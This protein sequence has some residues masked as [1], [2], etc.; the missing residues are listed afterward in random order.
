[1]SELK[2]ISP[3]LD[4]FAMG[5]PISDHNGVRCCPAM[6]N[7]ADNRYIVKI[8]S[9]PASQVQ[10]DALLL[11]GA[12]SDKQDALSYFKS[13]AS[14]ITEEAEILQKL[15]QLEGFIPFIKWQTVPMEEDNGYD[16]YLLSAYQLTLQ[17][18]LRNHP[19]THLEALN[20]GL[21]LCA[22]LTVCRRSGYIY[23][24]LKPNNI[25]I[26]PERGYRIGDLGFLKLSTLKYASLPERYRSQYTAPEI[27]DAYAAPNT[28][29]DIYAAGLIL[30]QVFNNGTLP[31]TG[32]AA[33]QES[34]APPAFADYEMAEIILKACAPDPADRW[35]DPVDMGQALVSYMQRNG[36]H[37]TPITPVAEEEVPVSEDEQVGTFEST[38]S[39]PADTEESAADQDEAE[40]PVDTSSEEAAEPVAE[41]A[42]YSEDEEGNLTFITDEEDETLPGDDAEEEITYTEV[43][44]EVSDMLAQADEIIAHPAPDPVVQPEAIDVPIPPL[45]EPESEPESENPEETQKETETECDAEAATEST[46]TDSEEAT[47]TVTDVSD[48]EEEEEAMPVKRK[49]H[50]LRNSLLILSALALLALGFL[51][52]KHYYLQPIEAI[53]LEESSSGA[54]TVLVTS[55]INEE[56][57]YVVCSD[58]YGNKHT[59]PVENGKAVFADLAPNSAYTI[60]VAVSGFHKL[61][62]DTTAGYTTPVQTN[63]VQFTAVTGTEDGSIILSFAIDGPDA[64]QWYI[65]YTSDSN[66]FKESIF[67]GHTLTLNG[68]TIGKEYTFSLR[69]DG[70]QRIG[71]TTEVTYTASKIIKATNLSITGFSENTLTASWSAPENTEVDRW[72]VRCYNDNGFDNTIVTTESTASFEITDT[73]ASYTVE[74]TAAGM[75][76]NERIFAAANSLLVNSFKVDK[77]DTNA[78]TLS[79]K[80][81]EN[82][83][84]DGWT[85]SYTVDG[86]AAKE[87]FFSGS[88]ATL[89]PVVPG[90]N[91]IFT[92]KPSDGGAVLGGELTY[93]AAAAPAFSAYGVNSETLEFRMCRRPSFTGWD[94]WDVSSSDYRTEFD[95]GEEAAFVIKRTVDY[96]HTEDQV[97][98][99]FVI[100]DEAG[101][102]IDADATESE[103]W[104]DMWVKGYC[105]LDVPSIPQT[106]GKYTVEIYFNGALAADVPF[107][108]N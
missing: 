14:G 3:M 84:Q 38:D 32:D 108:V 13:L 65:S 55:P 100:R 53:V 57:L 12:Y 75:S 69:P 79:W 83:P 60:K 67:S 62:G 37:D 5:D 103:Y 58:T 26:T 59:A 88:T 50:W 29:M 94:R 51:F 105:E 76:V 31:F 99:L 49:S 34:F 7:D 80:L 72:T 68:F 102:V 96:V 54:L 45:S 82:V 107:T 48:D 61:T 43:S 1:M 74:V 24:D 39:Q 63:I 47:D 87:L 4:N 16:V 71:G 73:T 27:S 78:L 95:A 81:P 9:N 85:L 86:S 42:I 97:V 106:P 20:L 52:Y 40:L 91:Y 30:Y 21:D 90:A 36:A 70:D 66:E 33:P 56:K 98:T 44:E 35:Q 89:S 23:V 101:A 10:L 17:K 104:Y 92:L 25:Y 18:Y 77:E 19:M 93:A 46:A 6:E 28:T 41:E 2:L 11:S 22:A 15:S 64:D 8:I